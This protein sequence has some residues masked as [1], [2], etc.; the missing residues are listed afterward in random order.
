MA[1][2][3]ES[4]N[5]PIWGRGEN[6]PGQPKPN[7]EITLFS[8]FYLMF[9]GQPRTLIWSGLGQVSKFDQ[10]LL[11]ALYNI[12]HPMPICPKPW[13]GLVWARWQNLTNSFYKPFITFAIPCPFGWNDKTSLFG[14]GATWH[15]RPT[16]P[17][18]R[19]HHV[20]KDLL[21]FWA[22]EN[23]KHCDIKPI[24][25]CRNAGPANVSGM[26]DLWFQK[27]NKNIWKKTSISTTKNKKH[28]NA[29]IIKIW[30]FHLKIDVC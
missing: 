5:W 18:P 2:W 11:Q 6:T 30:N 23:T 17:I 12:C 1:I 8:L 27:L 19:N 26:S 24:C 29:K 9:W 7:Q 20:S 14:K 21:I 25:N 4:W 28:K 15:T 22:A 13:F 16:H 10:F 3:R